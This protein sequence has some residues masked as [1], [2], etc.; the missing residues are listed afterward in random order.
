[1]MNLILLGESSKNKVEYLMVMN[2]IVAI[3]SSN[4]MIRPEILPSSLPNER[5]SGIIIKCH[6]PELCLDHISQS[7]CVLRKFE[8]VFV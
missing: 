2:R 4:S 6:E 1:M 5:K 7:K 8:L 3:L